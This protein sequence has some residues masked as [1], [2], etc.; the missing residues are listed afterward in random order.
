[1]A[2]FRRTSTRF[3]RCV[4]PTSA[5][6]LL[7]DTSAALALVNPGHALRQAVA[8]RVRGHRLGLAGHAAHETYSLLT[9]LPPPHR[10]SATVAHR[11]IEA[12]FPATQHL[13]ADQAS[14][15]L[16]VLATAGVAAG[17][18]YDGLVG[19]AALENDQ[20]L[21]SCDQRAMNTYRALGVR[22]EILN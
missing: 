18:V 16:P 17:A 1:M 20:L 7:L 10:I 22:F 21:I 5:E 9:R 11:L 8:E 14:S 6:I 3:G 15:A 19:L 13:D 12:N 2:V 4:L